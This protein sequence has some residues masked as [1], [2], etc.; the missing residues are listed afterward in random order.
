VI[1]WLESIR[2]DC[3]DLG[4]SG[5]RASGRTVVI[6]GSVAGEHQGGLLWTVVVAGEHQGGLLWTVVVAGEHQ[7]GLL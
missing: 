6:W 1:Q 5:W 4:I 3:C 2:E 7:G